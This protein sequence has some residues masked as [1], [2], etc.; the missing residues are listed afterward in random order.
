MNVK[1]TT[2]S[3]FVHKSECAD[4]NFSFKRYFY[5]HIEQ[6]TKKSSLELFNRN[7]NVGWSPLDMHCYS[8]EHNK[9]ISNKNWPKKWIWHFTTVL[10]CS[11]P[12]CFE[13]R[14]RGLVSLIVLHCW[15][16][17]LINYQRLQFT[18]RNPLPLLADLKLI[19]AISIQK[20]VI[21]T[22]IITGET[23]VFIWWFG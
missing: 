1:N 15:S 6:K 20:T 5:W 17:I 18:F 3:L 9:K 16:E 7:Q 11:P 4:I 12:L 23:E 14:T 2:T 21:Y 19:G 13:Q 8:I 10:L 22:A